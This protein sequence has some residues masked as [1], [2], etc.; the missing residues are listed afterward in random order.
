MKIINKIL[1]AAVLILLGVS[2]AGIILF[3]SSPSGNPDNPVDNPNGNE[4][5]ITNFQFNGVKVVI[6]PENYETIEKPVAVIS[7]SS[8]SGKKCIEIK[9]GAGKPGG[10]KPG[11]GI[12]P[13]VFGKVVCSFVIPKTA[14]YRMWGRRWWMDACGNSFTIIIKG[15]K[16]VIYYEKGKKKKGEIPHTFGDDASYNKDLGLAWKWTREEVYYFEK[17]SYTI[18]ILNREDG[19]KLD[20]IL[21]AEKLDEEDDFPYTPTRIEK[22]HIPE[23]TE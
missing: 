13:S 8:A 14:Y 5:I 18:S 21:F 2:A 19:V 12:Y 7:D 15:E 3:K 6:E 20:Q 23:T 9:E 1:I 10:K 17:G 16:P 22:P 11:G 4:F